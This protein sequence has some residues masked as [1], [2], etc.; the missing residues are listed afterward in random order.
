[1]NMSFAEKENTKANDEVTKILSA[2]Y[3]FGNHEGSTKLPEVLINNASFRDNIK[4]D[5]KYPRIGH[6]T[7]GRKKELVDA[8]SS[9]LD[10]H[11]ILGVDQKFYSEIASQI[12]DK[13]IAAHQAKNRAAGLRAD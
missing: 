2:Q 3:R 11:R 7:E 8:Y 5:I 4:S 10:K 6:F 9:I 13:I 1:M 12:V